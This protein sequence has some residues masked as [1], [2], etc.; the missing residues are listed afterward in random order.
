[1]PICVL[2]ESGTGAV[3][4]RICGK[5]DEEKFAHLVEYSTSTYGAYLSPN[6]EFASGAD[7]DNGSRGF[8][9][10]GVRENRCCLLC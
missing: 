10:T 1:M 8:Y 6:V 9:A 7:I 5:A 4:K 2:S 3:P